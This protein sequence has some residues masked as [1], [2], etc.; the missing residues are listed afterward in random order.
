MPKEGERATAHPVAA[1]HSM[2]AW[3]IW[4]LPLQNVRRA[5]QEMARDVNATHGGATIR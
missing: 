5:M 4:P 2:S 1:E 3:Q